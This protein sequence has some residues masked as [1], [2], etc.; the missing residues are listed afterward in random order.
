MEPF[1]YA[2]NSNNFKAFWSAEVQMFKKGEFATDVDKF[3]NEI[4]VSFHIK[5]VE[6][7]WMSLSMPLVEI[8]Y[9]LYVV[10]IIIV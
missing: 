9:D 3:M 1:E 2:N 4:S 10:S 8:G 7:T 5:L 6:V